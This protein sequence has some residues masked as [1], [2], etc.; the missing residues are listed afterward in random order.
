MPK[1][2]LAMCLFTSCLFQIACNSGTDVTPDQRRLENSKNDPLAKDSLASTEGLAV[3]SSSSTSSSSTGENSVSSPDSS[4]PVYPEP[5]CTS[6][7]CLTAT[8]IV[9]YSPNSALNVDVSVLG[10]TLAGCYIHNESAAASGCILQIP[11]GNEVIVSLVEKV[12]GAG[13]N[14]VW[15]TSDAT[16]PCKD[17]PTSEPC[18]FGA[19]K[20]SNTLIIGTKVVAPP[21][22]TFKLTVI[23]NGSI[24]VSATGINCGSDC[25]E[26]YPE[27]KSVVLTVYGAPSG[28]VKWDGCSASDLTCTVLMNSVKTVTVSKT[29]KLTVK[30]NEATSVTVVGPGLNCGSDCEESYNENSPVVLTVNDA[31]PGSLTWTGCVANDLSCT[32]M[33]NGGKEVTVNRTHKLTVTKSGLVTVTGTG[34]SCGTDCE[35]AY[36][37]NRSVT[38]NATGVQ[39][40][41]VT[42]TGCVANDLTC[43]TTMNA[44]K[45]VNVVANKIFKLTVV[46]TGAA[47][48][49]ATGLNC[50]TD[51]DENYSENTDVTLTATGTQSGLVTWTGCVAT[52]LTCTVKMTAAKNVTV[53][54]APLYKLT[55]NVLPTGS[56]TLTSSAALSGKNWGSCGTSCQYYPG[57]TSIVLTAT[58]F[59]ADSSAQWV[60]APECPSAPVAT[61]TTCTIM[62]PNQ[63]KSVTV[64]FVPPVLYPFTLTKGTQGSVT[65]VDSNGGSSICDKNCTNFSKTYRDGT[66]LTVTA[67]DEPGVAFLRWTTIGGAASPCGTAKSCQIVMSALKNINAVY[68]YP[69]NIS[70]NAGLDKISGMPGITFADCGLNCRKYSILN[71]TSVTLTANNVP[72]WAFK[73]WTIQYLT[74]GATGSVTSSSS[75]ISING[76]ASVIANYTPLYKLTVQ[77]AY[78]T[79]SF[80]PSNNCPPNTNYCYFESGQSVTATVSTSATSKGWSNCPNVISDKVCRVIKA[81]SDQTIQINLPEKYSLNVFVSGPVGAGVQLPSSP[82]TEICGPI[83]KYYYENQNVSFSAT[84]VSGWNYAF[85]GDCSGQICSL[86]MSGNKSVTLVYTQIP[87]PTATPTATPTITPPPGG[88][89]MDG[90]EG[91]QVTLTC[92]T[93]KKISVISF[94]SYGLPT[95]YCGSGNYAINPACHSATSKS[96]V[97]SQCLNKTTCSVWADNTT[98]GDPCVNIYKRLAIQYGCQ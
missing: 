43:T 47:T 13:A 16:H 27:N 57:G 83:C 50:G 65:V 87:T 32:V 86:S 78:G 24:T 38:L 51:C 55:T 23:K 46:K 62:M 90:N 81:A 58:P 93:G 77:A 92:P 74:P 94:A 2:C 36:N 88:L 7:T 53:N 64:S 28:A 79:I 60:N 89:C 49:T 72:G 66:L 73:S 17:R 9:A 52:D 6:T 10:M 68:G 11:S 91:N 54:V 3:A 44:A 18:R 82:M 85:S 37:E 1:I 84:P 95:G 39:S 75:T 56:G 48:I 22:K 63:D 35:E 97:E 26:L 34:I 5:I 29:Y 15:T 98:F 30:K 59:I 70:S 12:Q 71:G 69:V 4:S 19:V 67:N 80:S 96:V 61:S 31:E 40:G 41:S 20:S 21:V 76:Y 42:W 45:T 8:K 14:T 33:M 25:D